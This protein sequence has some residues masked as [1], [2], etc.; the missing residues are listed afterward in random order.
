MKKAL[1]IL[2]LAVSLV[3]CEKDEELRTDGTKP[4]VTTVTFKKAP[5]GTIT[6]I[7]VNLTLSIPEKGSV[8]RVDILRNT[9]RANGATQSTPVDGLNTFID[10]SDWPSNPTYYTFILVLQDNTEIISTQYQVKE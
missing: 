10:P 2:F 8:K 3:G 6:R 5:Q 9:T 7:Q 4:S 1:L